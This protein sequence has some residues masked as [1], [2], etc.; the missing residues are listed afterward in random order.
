MKYLENNVVFF[1]HIHP[2][3]VENSYTKYPHHENSNKSYT[4][5]FLSFFRNIFCSSF[6]NYCKRFPFSPELLFFDAEND[7]FYRGPLKIFWISWESTDHSSKAWQSPIVKTFFSPRFS[8]L[9]EIQSRFVKRLNF[10]CGVTYSG[11]LGIIN[12]VTKQTKHHR[13]LVVKASHGAQ[14]FAVFHIHS[15]PPIS[16]TGNLVH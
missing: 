2:P 13:W 3:L 7:F 12:Q 10:L 11:V 9:C 4:L 1:I 6:S 16:T 8:I 14:T 5:F 15:S